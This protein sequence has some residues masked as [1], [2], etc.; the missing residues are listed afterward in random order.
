MLEVRVVVF[1]RI[2]EGGGKLR[3]FILCFYKPCD[4][5]LKPSFWKLCNAIQVDYSWLKKCLSKRIRPP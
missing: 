5:N 1:I 4:M 2:P 3:T